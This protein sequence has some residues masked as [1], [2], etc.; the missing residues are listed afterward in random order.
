MEGHAGYAEEG[1]DIV[2][3]AVTSVSDLTIHLCEEYFNVPV[4]VSADTS[5]NLEV[6]AVSNFEVA[7]KLF[8]GLYDY[9]ESVKKD[10]PKCISIKFLEV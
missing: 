1:Q 9:V 10:Y 4:K 3:A 2:C 8:S 7:H 5:G 6:D